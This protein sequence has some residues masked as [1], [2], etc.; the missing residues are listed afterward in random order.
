MNFCKC[1]H[2][3]YL[4]IYVKKCLECHFQRGFV[5]VVKG[6]MYNLTEYM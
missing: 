2:A 1:F 3:E 5:L 4:K 6:E